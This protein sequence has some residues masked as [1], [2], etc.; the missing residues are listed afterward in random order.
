MSYAPERAGH[1]RRFG[2]RRPSVSHRRWSGP[3]HQFDLTRTD[4]GSLYLRRWWL[5]STPL[6]GVLLHRMSAPDARPTLHDHP[7]SFVSIV[8]RGGY[9]E[10]RL[11]PMT[12]TV[13]GHVVRRVNVVRK[14]DAHTI[15]RLLRNPTW[16]LL[17]V[18]KH[19]RTW[20][21]W[22]PGEA[23]S[24]NHVPDGAGGTER[25]GTW[26]A[27]VWRWTK[28]DAF[29]SGHYVPLPGEGGS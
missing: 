22:E 24:W 6:G 2:R 29:D 27:R 8:L 17:L 1:R 20:G 15:T 4:D 21:F 16:T 19:H 12:F 9:V 25:D 5:F 18:G 11:D 13:S 28:H 10:D 26:S 23:R 14:H 3:Y 7:F